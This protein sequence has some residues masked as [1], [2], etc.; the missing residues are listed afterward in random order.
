[1]STDLKVAE[2]WEGDADY[3]ASY[4]Y[5]NVLASLFNL[6]SLYYKHSITPTNDQYTAQITLGELY[7]TEAYSMRVPWK[8]QAAHVV[9]V[10]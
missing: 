6:T 2:L 3:K 1:M 9:L 10:S 8:V 4:L 5:D 7:K